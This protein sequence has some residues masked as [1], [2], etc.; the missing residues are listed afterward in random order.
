MLALPKFKV[1]HEVNLKPILN[2]LGVRR[3]FVQGTAELTGK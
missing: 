1:E 2:L 3:L